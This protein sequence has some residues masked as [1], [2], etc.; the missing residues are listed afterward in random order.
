MAIPPKDLAA[1][2]QDYSQRGLDLPELDPDPLRQFQA[3]LKEAHDS[4]LIEPNAMTLATVDSAGRPWTR[5]VLL[6]ACDPRGFTFFT[7]YNGAKAAH[8]EAQSSVAVTFWWG[9]LE[10]Q[11]NITGFVSKVD[12]QESEAYFAVRPLA[13]QLGAW[14]SP[15]SAPI[16]GRAH[17]ERLFAESER[18]FAG[19]D[20]PCPPHWGGYRLAPETIEFWQG[21]R[22]RLHDRFRFTRNGETQWM[23]ERLAP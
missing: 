2:R 5:T 1:L 20:V 17:L 22:S 18:R 9:A 15:Q 10:R 8:L 19:G 23:V 14:A 3:W 11:V 21:R 7:N 6:K 4:G 12:R 16:E 13:S